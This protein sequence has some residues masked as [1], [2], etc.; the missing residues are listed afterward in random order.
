MKPELTMV[1][2]RPSGHVTEEQVAVNNLAAFQRAVGGYI[3]VVP[4]CDLFDYDNAIRP[5][6]ALCDEEG[7]LKGKPVNEHA[8][9]M[10]NR[11]LEHRGVTHN[12]DFLVGDVVFLFGPPEVMAQF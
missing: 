11:A 8:T 5:C 1:V 9:R 10:W 12:P 4:S 6:I 3:E 7:K 2:V